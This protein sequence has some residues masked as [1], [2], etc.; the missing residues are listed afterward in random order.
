MLTNLVSFATLVAL[1][2]TMPDPQRGRP[3]RDADSKPVTVAVVDSASGKPVTNFTYQAWYDAPGRQS[4]PEDD[5]WTVVNSPAGTFEIQT[6]AACRVSVMAKAPDCIGGYPMLSEFVIK[7]ADD[8]RRVVVRLRRGIT[9][10]GTVRDARNNAPIAGVTVAP[11]IHVPPLWQPDEDKQ[12]KSGDDGRY[13]VRGVDSERGV[14]ASHADYAEIRSGKAA[15]PIQDIFLAPGETIA[16]T[17]V[18]TNGKP[19]EGV[20]GGDFDGRHPSSGKDGRL[21]I[22]TTDPASGLFFRKDG[23]IGR[24]LEGKEIRGKRAKPDNFVVVMEPSIGAQRQGRHT[25]RASPSWRSL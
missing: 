21:V 7:S 16:L 19:L 8:P 6:P 2:A 22:R 5:V 13:E 9:V 3:G 18:D 25:G 23:F 15:G 10:N 4:R 1:V 12:V 14:S 11:V 20:T 24:R 17:V